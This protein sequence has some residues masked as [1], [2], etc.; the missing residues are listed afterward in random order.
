MHTH[1]RSSLA[2]HTVA[3]QTWSQ[4]IAKSWHYRELTAALRE[5]IKEEKEKANNL[6]RE[7]KQRIVPE[8]INVLNPLIDGI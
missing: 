4:Y 3:L 2:N 6:L 7:K 5:E 1:L 8:L